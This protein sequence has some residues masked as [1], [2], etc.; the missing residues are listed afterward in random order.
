M[1][2]TITRI[3]GKHS[4]S[5]VYILIVSYLCGYIL[6]QLFAFLWQRSDPFVRDLFALS[7]DFSQLLQQPWTAI[8]YSFFHASF[9]HCFFNAIM[10][11]FVGILFMNL[12]TPK[13]FLGIYIA[14]V[15]AGGLFFMLTYAVFPVFAHREDYLLGG[16]AGIMAVLIFLTTYTPTL[17][18]YLFGVWAIPLWVLGVLMVAT[19]LLS[20]P[21]S[22]AGG[23]IAHLGGALV[24]ILYGLFLKGKLSFSLPKR[25]QQA[26]T[27]P[28]T[29]EHAQE[30]INT[31][32][33]K[34]S[35]SGYDSLTNEEKRYLFLAS[36]ENANQ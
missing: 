7:Q 18:I 9:I 1:N 24:G 11:Y 36:R 19:D 12:F 17:R 21:V 27:S 2:R 25:P 22:N 16:S 4:L 35:K 20:I 6:P 32:L 26:P 23:H 15:V 14:G 28:Y 8:T 34:I 30:R 5:L 13:R 33:D 10:L 3:W 29:N 31:I